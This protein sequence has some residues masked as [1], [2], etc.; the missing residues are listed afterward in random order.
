MSLVHAF[1]TVLRSLARPF[2][3]AIG[4][5]APAQCLSCRQRIMLNA[6]LCAECWRELMLIEDPCCDRLGIPFP[7]DQGGELLSPGAIANPP[8]WDRLRAATIF[9]PV[10]RHLIHALKYRDR[11]EA[12]LLMSRLM[13]R[14]GQPLLDGADVI[15]PVPLHR[16]RLWTRRFNQAALLARAVCR[17]SHVSYRPEL[18]VRHRLTQQQALLRH[19][20]RMKNVRQAF[21]VPARWIPA[22]EGRN[23]ILVDDVLTTGATAGAATKALKDAGARRVDVLTFALVHGPKD[24][25]M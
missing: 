6:A 10:S 7:Y 11:H 15:V 21:R 9:G 13:L 3:T 4:L 2:E 25:H 18:L 12:A 20:D 23:I 19:R 17:A 22:V 5:L 24:G 14:A 1:P 8:D 16:W